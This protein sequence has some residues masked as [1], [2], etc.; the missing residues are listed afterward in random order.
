ME[1]DV[2]YEIEWDNKY[3]CIRST[4][5]RLTIIMFHIGK[6]YILE[7]LQIIPDMLL[8]VEVHILGR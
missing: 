7:F 5:S 3:K 2:L 8:Y 6:K 1:A 4:E